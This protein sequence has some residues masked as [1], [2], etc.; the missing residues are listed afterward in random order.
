[1][2]KT[3]YGEATDQL[4]LI[5]TNCK[6][7]DRKCKRGAYCMQENV[8]E[9]FYI[10]NHND[11]LEDVTAMLIGKIEGNYSK[12]SRKLL[13]EDVQNTSIRWTQH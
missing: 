3:V 9:H 4:K 1:M 7:K 8:Y 6:S 10:Y 2:L 12:N 13:D 11:F 5:W